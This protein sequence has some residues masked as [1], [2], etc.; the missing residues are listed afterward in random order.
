MPGYTLS[1]QCFAASA[2]FL[3]GIPELC[4]VTESKW[5]A[6][7][8]GED[9]GA[10]NAPQIRAVQS[11]TP[12]RIL[13]LPRKPIRSGVRVGA[14]LERSPFKSHGRGW[15]SRI[16]T[17]SRHLHTT[18]RTTLRA[19]RSLSAIRGWN[20]VREFALLPMSYAFHHYSHFFYSSPTL[21]FYL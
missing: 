10:C 21:F 4:N 11:F 12:S 7:N 15:R 9:T 8:E 17:R 13:R 20:F 5:V 3:P 16:P 6:F 18:G 1:V 14:T 2:P 19:G